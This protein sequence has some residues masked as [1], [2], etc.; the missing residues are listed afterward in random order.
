MFGHLNMKEQL[1]QA[2]ELNR[3]LQAKLAKAVGDVE[4]IAMMA[5]VE[6]DQDDEEVADNE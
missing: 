4:Y 2:Q 1:R 3:K 6:L 5:D